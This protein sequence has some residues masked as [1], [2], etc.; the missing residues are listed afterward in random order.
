MKPL[1]YLPALVLYFYGLRIVNIGCTRGMETVMMWYK[2][3]G[4]ALYYYNYYRF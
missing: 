1:H 3:V 4:V 2:S